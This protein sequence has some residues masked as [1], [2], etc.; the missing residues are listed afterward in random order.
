M[1]Q[2]YE[3]L[4]EKYKRISLTQLRSIAATVHEG[5]SRVA[6]LAYMNLGSFGSLAKRLGCDDLLRIRAWIQ[7][8]DDEGMQKKFWHTVDVSSKL[9]GDRLRDSLIS[10]L[11]GVVAESQRQLYNPPA[12]QL[13]GSIVNLVKSGKAFIAEIHCL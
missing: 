7:F 3:V 1:V 6:Q 2:T 11:E 10:A 8:K 13:R 4:R 9:S 12:N 5:G